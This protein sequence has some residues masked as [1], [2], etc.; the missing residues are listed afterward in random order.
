MEKGSINY[1]RKLREI[2]IDHKGDCKRCPLGE[3]P[4]VEDNLCPRLSHPMRWDDYKI[5]E[6]VKEV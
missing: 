2:C 5:A 1:L 6:M 3:K 4:R